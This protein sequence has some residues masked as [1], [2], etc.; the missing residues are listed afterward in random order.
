MLM[1]FGDAGQHPNFLYAK[2]YFLYKIIFLFTV[3]ILIYNDI[4]IR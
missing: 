1:I 3:I 2:K 4:I